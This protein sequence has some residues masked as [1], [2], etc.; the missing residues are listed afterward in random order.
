[1]SDFIKR[2]ENKIIN[3]NHE[4]I[5]KLIVR[6]IKQERSNNNL[7]FNHFHIYLKNKEMIEF[8]MKDIEKQEE[9][10]KLRIKNLEETRLDNIKNSE[11]IIK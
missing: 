11:N 9:Q 10:I 6:K 3:L 1:M 8:L 7:I 4:L 2:I 5:T